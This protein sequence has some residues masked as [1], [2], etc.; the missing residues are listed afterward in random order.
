MQAVRIGPG[1][2]VTGQAMYR[3]SISSHHFYDKLL[4]WHSDIPGQ[5]TQKHAIV[6]P[7][8]KKPNMDQF[9]M[10]SYRPVSKLTFI[11][12]FMERFAVSRFHEHARA[13][14]LFPVH[15]SAYRSCHSTETAIVNILGK[16]FQAVDSDKVC[17][18]V[19]LD[20]TADFDTVDH[21]IL[22]TVLKERF[23]VQKGVFDWF[24][25][26]LEGRTQCV[27]APTGRSEPV[28]LTCGVPQGSVLGPVK[29]IAYTEDLHTATNKFPSLHHCFADD[30]HLLARVA[31]NDVNLARRCLESCVTDIHDWCARRR[32]QLNPEKSELIWFG[33]RTNLDRL[34]AMHTTNHLDQADIKP[35]DCVRDLAVLLDSSLSMR[36]HITKVTSTYFFHLR[37]LHVLSRILDID[38][39]RSCTDTCRLLQLCARRSVRHRISAAAA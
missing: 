8:L 6:K 3:R 26:Y 15:Q 4:I 10:K 13:H 1:P 30:S 39:L 18:L 33:S 29:V 20:L 35:I 11:S 5:S 36:E 37:R 2:D 21:S 23:G 38:D 14:R 34:Q 27:S 24:N 17:A 9:D 32:L 7:L 28:E 22:L 16:I 12:K 25:S 31:I 19:L